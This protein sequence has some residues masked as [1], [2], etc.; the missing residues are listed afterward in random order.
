MSASEIKAVDAEK[1][2]AEPG[3][4]P[5]E[6]TSPGKLELPDYACALAEFDYTPEE[7]RR[8]LRKID[9]RVVVTLGCLYCVS[10]I[11]RVNLGAA[12]IA[13]MGRELELVGTRYSIVTLVFFISYTL[14]QQ[15]SIV[16]VRK[17]GPRKFLSLVVLLWGAVTIGMGFVADWE[18]LAGLRVVLG[19]FEA[20]LFPGSV[21]LLSTWYT[22]YEVGKRYSVFYLVGS[23]ASAFAGI[24]A[25]GLQQMDGLANLRGWRW[26]FIIE[27]ILTCLL[28]FVSYLLLVD[29]PDSETHLWSFLDQRAKDWIVAR[30]N[31]DRGDARP[32]TF[33]LC[34]YLSPAKDWKVW[35]YAVIFCNVTTINYALAF[36]LPV[37]LT[38][39]MGFSVGAAQCLI[40]P[41]YV[42]AGALIYGSAYFSDKHRLRAPF[43][44]MNMI[45]AVVGLPIMGFHRN[46][47]VRY[48]GVFLVTSGALASIPI[49][50]S[51]QANNIRGQWKRAFCSGASIG[52]AGIGGIVGG[53]IFRAQDAPYYRPGLYICI[54]LLGL[55][56]LLVGCLT[57][58]YRTLNRQAD[59]GERILE[60]EDGDFPLDF[61][62]TY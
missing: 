62:Y 44:V 51:Y 37:I 7:E 11:D 45:I 55:S 59:R 17:I 14:F 21:Y 16:I 53:L 5:V 2:G 32:E 23:G 13:G 10:L 35:A 30:V 20:G 34:K 24:L 4:R 54:G 56:I 40:A 38:E 42:A 43:L 31:A 47:G 41:P 48:F 12:N 15:P 6:S 9:R 33:N 50:L 25:Y 26:I 36:F 19:L 58:A 28:A 8:I 60:N 3:I 22:R 46:A 49:V 57:A 52:F 27:G 18:Q 1:M 61:R 39:N 29:F